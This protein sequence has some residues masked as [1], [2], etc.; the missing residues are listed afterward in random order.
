[1]RMRNIIY[2]KLILKYKIGKHL[3]D[4][5]AKNA[6]ATSCHKKKAMYGIS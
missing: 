5:I 3:I 2:T 6:K 1:M 4:L